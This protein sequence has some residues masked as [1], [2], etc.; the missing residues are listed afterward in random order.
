VDSK[1][2]ALFGTDAYSGDG[3]HRSPR[4]GTRMG[5]ARESKNRRHGGHKPQEFYDQVNAVWRDWRLLFREPVF[6]EYSQ[7]KYNNDRSVGR[8]KTTYNMSFLLACAAE[9]EVQRGLSNPLV[10]AL[11]NEMTEELSRKQIDQETLDLV[12]AAEQRKFKTMEFSR[13]GNKLI[14]CLLDARQRT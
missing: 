5:H 8:K 1:A 3:Q 7:K 14:T 4:Y 2:T 13:I 11:F 9:A 12:Y 10:M 6:V